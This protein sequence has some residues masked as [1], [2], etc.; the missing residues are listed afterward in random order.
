MRARHIVSLLA[1]L[2]IAAVTGCGGPATAASSPDSQLAFAVTMTDDPYR[3]QPMLFTVPAG[4]TV[5][6]TN[7]A[8]D[9]HTVTDAASRATNSADAA[10]PAGAQGWDSGPINSGQ[11]FSHTFTTPGTYKY[12]CTIHESLG[13]LGTVTVM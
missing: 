3:F 4:T 2:G 10:L 12:F 9:Q 5:T 8:H 1:V 7:T 11:A 13:M 6:W